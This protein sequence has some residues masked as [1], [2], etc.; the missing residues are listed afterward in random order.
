MP[1]MKAAKLTFCFFGRVEKNSELLWL[2]GELAISVSVKMGVGASHE[3]EEQLEA[4]LSL[5]DA[6]R[7]RQEQLRGENDNLQARLTAQASHQLAE[8]RSKNNIHLVQE[9]APL[10]RRV[11]FGLAVTIPLAFHALLEL[12]YTV[13]KWSR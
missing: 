9:R 7:A 8:R 4:A 6:A 3:Y 5:L 10:S 13:R 12:V 11:L 1:I 2:V